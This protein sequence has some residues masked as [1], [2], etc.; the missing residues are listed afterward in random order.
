AVRDYLAARYAALKD[1][2]PADG[3]GRAEILV[4]VKDP[5]PVQVFV[6]GF[7]V[8]EL[9]VDLTNINNVK[10]R[11]DGTLVALAYDGKVWLLRDTDGDGIED[12]AELF[13]DNKTGLRAPIGM[14]LTPPGYK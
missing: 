1:A 14:D 6:P 9:P 2:L 5:P 4:P 13:W 11:P 7:T 3:D 12:R 8:R 10:Y